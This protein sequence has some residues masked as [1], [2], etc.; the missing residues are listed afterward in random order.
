[1]NEELVQIDMSRHGLCKEIDRLRSALK[2][3]HDYAIEREG[4]TLDHIFIRR[5]AYTALQ[6][7]AEAK[8]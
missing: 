7:P 6:P 4:K 5:C 1:M 2:T 3:L 8:E